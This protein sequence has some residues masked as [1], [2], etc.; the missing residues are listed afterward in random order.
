MKWR[1]YKKYN[2]KHA[3]VL[4]IVFGFAVASWLAWPVLAVQVAIDTSISASIERH[5]GAAPDTVFTTDQIGYVFY[6]DGDNSCVYRKTT[7]AGATWGTSVQVSPANCR[8]VSVWYDQWTP[9]D[10]SGSNIYIITTDGTINALRYNRL[11]TSTDT[12]QQGANPIDIS[13]PKTNTFTNHDNY[14][15]ISKGTDGALYA[16][17]FDSDAGDQSYVL[18]C[19]TT[20]GTAGNWTDS[21][22]GLMNTG[23]A[24]NFG[25]L[26]QPLANGDMIAIVNDTD[27]QDMISK[28]YH[29]GTNS[30]D[31]GWT[32]IDAN[33]GSDNLYAGTGLSAVVD[34][35]T[36][37]VYLAYTADALNIGNG[38]DDFRTAIYSGGSW[39]ARTPIINNDP[40]RGLVTPYLFFD[41]NS[42]N[43]YAAYIAR[44]T[45]ATPTSANIYW[46]LSTDGMN[47]WGAEQGPINSAASDLRGLHFN[48][49]SN[50]RAYLTWMDVSAAT[51]YGDTIADLTPPA[52]TQNDYRFFNNTDSTDVGTPLAAQNT[53]ASL[54]NPGDQFRTRLVLDMAG[55]N[56]RA[57]LDDFKLQYAGKGFGSCESPSGTPSTYTDVTTSTPIS[58]YDNPTPSNG[59]ALTPNANDPSHDIN[60]TYVE[61]SPFTSI[62]PTPT[63]D[64]S[65]WDFSLYDNGANGNTT[66]CLRVVKN[67][68]TV[69][70]SYS[71]YP[72]ITTAISNL[73]PNSPDSLGQ[74]KVDDS[75]VAAASW[76]NENSIKFTANVSD[77]DSS[78]TLQLCVETKPLGT[79]FSGNEDACGTGVSYSGSPVAASVTIG[80][81]SE[82]EY[83][84]RARV[85]DAAG[86][87]SDWISYASS[88]RNV[89]ASWEGDGLSDAISMTTSTAGVGDTPFDGVSGTAS[90]PQT[91][92]TG[93][94][95]PRII[96]P[97]ITN[98]TR[99]LRWSPSIGT[100]STYATRVDTEFTSWPSNSF[101]VLRGE[102]GGNQ[103]WRVDIAGTGGTAGQLRLRD[104]ANTII[105]DS[106]ST[107]IPLN[108]QVRFEVVSNAGAMT[109]NVYDGQSTNILISVS[110]TVGS[111]IDTI[112]YG[113]VFSA[114]PPDHYWDNF[115]FANTA[116]EI[117]PA[118]DYGIDT[119]APTGGTVYDGTTP[120]VDEPFNDGSLSSLSANWSGFNA[121]ISGLSHY[122]YSIGT[123]PG[124]TDIQNWTNVNAD[125]SVTDSGLSLRTTQPY[126]VNVRAVDNANNMTSVSS[127]G[128]HVLPTLSFGIS[129]DTIDFDTLNAAN[130]YTDTKS[131]TTTTSTN[132]YGGY[133]VRIFATDLLR[134]SSQETIP[135][136]N[137]GT[138]ASPDSWQNG[139][140]GFG[141]TSNDTSIQ[142]VNKF[143]SD[144]C[145]G[146]SA[147]QAP[148]C[149]A[150]FSQNAPG[151]IVADHTAN[152]VGTPITNQQ[153][154]INYRVTTSDTQPAAPDYAS[155]LVYSVT[156]LY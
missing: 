6:A 26:I 154:T 39:S 2:A 83:H 141:Y 94:Y 99:N 131:T 90:A 17:V 156:P 135:D 41:R 23:G 69:L 138:Y 102:T 64:G 52:Y 27:N 89:I 119:T 92:A 67:D 87:Y 112:D 3:I 72:E 68:G 30:W 53:T 140:I 96:F 1:K 44:T 129:S 77:P 106:G 21:L 66:Y 151:D 126:Y 35:Q 59:A 29:S 144:P 48:I 110:G 108:S 139:D 111:S 28:V 85:K 60:Q 97:T 9:G 40:T 13:S 145:P 109:V 15:S 123:T 100:H 50:Q 107:T 116:S 103:E 8:H 24:K 73:P 58:Y 65:M 33:A 34:K 117:G 62:N 14:P 105:A 136:F 133:V 18:R 120:G 93:S 22:A 42:G 5:D 38:D 86:A 47:S 118:R 25:L 45:P 147:L 132:A 113:T 115:A 7:N 81:Q 149:Y 146:G 31:A 122:D 75:P 128:Q 20:C 19:T 76:V 142:G 49:T 134:A 143:Q 104:A 32:T 114:S 91:S 137:G 70:S 61:A 80:S 46:K 56:A 79:A 71:K 10:N 130:S 4:A 148:G 82:G 36:N 152:V 95:S 153:F 84:W 74:S 43:V 121:D 57:G 63:G 88:S 150:T 101:S 51:L 155:T 37:N 98:Q 124:G 125:T 54:A 127:N 16:G 78:D 55:D 12:L 11:D